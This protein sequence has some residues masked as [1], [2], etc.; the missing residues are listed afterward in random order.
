MRGKILAITEQISKLI[1]FCLKINNFH[2]NLCLVKKLKTIC[3][4]YTINCNAIVS[5]S[6]KT[7][8]HS[9]DD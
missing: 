4:K 2:L 7:K 8:F 1:F 6:F 9:N 3:S 5:V